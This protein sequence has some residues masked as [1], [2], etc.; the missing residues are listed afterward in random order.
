[1]PRSG[2]WISEGR[3][4]RRRRNE[5]LERASEKDLDYSASE[6]C[7]PTRTLV[8]LAAHYRCRTNARR[9]YLLRSFPLSVGREEEEEEEEAG[10]GGNDGSTGMTRE[11]R[12]ASSVSLTN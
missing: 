7:N 3:E 11:Y 9:G 5:K 1:M 4:G 2:R 12:G 8:P 6:I 10:G